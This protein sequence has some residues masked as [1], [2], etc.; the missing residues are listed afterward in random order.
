[1]KLDKM[2][3]SLHETREESEQVRRDCQAM[4]KAY[5]TSEENK[6]FTLEQQL[7]E[8]QAQLIMERHEHHDREETY[9]QHHA[10]TEALKKKHQLILN[11]NNLLSIKVWVFMCTVTILQCTL[12]R[13]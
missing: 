5:Q 9:R 8:H 10:E 13:E 6:A 3:K 1:L 2:T 12:V 11:E 7:K 4:M